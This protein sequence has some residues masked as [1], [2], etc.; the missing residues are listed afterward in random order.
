MSGLPPFPWQFSYW[1]NLTKL[2][3]SQTLSHAYLIGG[4]Q[5]IGKFDF[6]SQFSKYLL[7]KSPKKNVACGECSDCLLGN[8]SP[9]PD[10]IQVCA[11]ADSKVIKVEQIRSLSNFF[12]QTSHSGQA[13]VA[14]LNDAHYLNTAAAN[15]LL[16]TLEEPAKK[17]YIFLCSSLPSSLMATIRSR[18]QRI[19]MVNPSKEN[20]IKWL[21]DRI[22]SRYDLELLAEASDNRPMYALD[23]IEGD[24]LKHEK[25]V[26]SNFIELT[27]SNI[28]LQAAVKLIIDTGETIAIGSLIRFLRACIKNLLLVKSNKTISPE[29]QE[30]LTICHNSNLP[31]K[32][33]VLVLFKFYDDL[34]AAER[35]LLDTNLNSQ[36]IV[37]SIVWEWS[38][39]SHILLSGS[40]EKSA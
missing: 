2:H 20:T 10:Y 9:H 25:V 21:K 38:K 27:R 7:C 30:L 5:G 39:M 19:T 17:T 8:N 34:V 13:K 11:E 36:L 12:S 37:E 16:K 22:D 32:T 33:A 1:E 15:A 35:E 24:I 28:S 26:I 6:A 3:Q 40:N 31:L 18:C 29:E 4:P 23:L 14:V